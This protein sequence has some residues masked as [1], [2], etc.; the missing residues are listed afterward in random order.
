MEAVRRHVRA[1]D[2]VELAPLESEIAGICTDIQALPQ[3]HRE[4]FRRPLVGLMSDLDDL[5]AQLRAGL[6]RLGRQIGETGQ[7]RQAV[8]A[9]GKPGGQTGG[10][11]GGR[12]GGPG[13][14]GR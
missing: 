10:R 8:A 11:G 6:E 12:G 1:G 14:R 3:G 7:R 5:A 4:A 9:Y 13:G 2:P